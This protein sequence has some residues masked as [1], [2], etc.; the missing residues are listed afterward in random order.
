MA[1]D[2]NLTS[3]TC[4]FIRDGSPVEWMPSPGVFTHAPAETV[5]SRRTRSLR[6]SSGAGGAT[7]PQAPR[8]SVHRRPDAVGASLPRSADEIR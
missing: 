7:A 8:R 4:V 3:D 1:P 5:T 2:P 6:S